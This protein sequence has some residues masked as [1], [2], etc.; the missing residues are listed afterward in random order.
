[1]RGR[2]PASGIAIWILAAAAAV[3]LLHVFRSILWPFALAVVLT[4]LIQAAIRAAVRVWPGARPR[5]L[6]LIAGVAVLTAL[7]GVGLVVVPGLWELRNE[8]PILQQRLDDLLVRV[9]HALAL[10]DPITLEA[11]TGDLDRRAV[12]S[13]VFGGLQGAA[14]SLILTA[15]FVFFLLASQALIERRLHLVVVGPRSRLALARTVRGVETY[16]WVQTITSVI[17]GAAAG[18]VML[19]VGLDHWL[20]W[21]IALFALSYIPF[22]GVAVGSIGPAL[23]AILQFPSLWPSLVIFLGIQLIAFVV[24]NLIWPKLQADKQNMDPSVTLLSLGVWSIVW[25]LPGAFLAVPLTL[26]LIYQLAA[27]ERLHWIAILLSN[28]GDPLP[29]GAGRE[30]RRNSSS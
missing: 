21:A 18:L 1:V 19:A 2:P 28:D 20:I 6:L 12:A 9:N 14:S 29:G 3:A 10:E 26:A 17:N 24:G 25:G 16:L 15:L 11:L 13:W 7:L 27:S 8:L 22:I 5:V 23:F 30:S 4:I